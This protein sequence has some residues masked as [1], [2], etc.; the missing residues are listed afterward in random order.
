[1][2]KVLDSTVRSDR[3]GQVHVGWDLNATVT[4]NSGSTAS[5]EIGIGSSIAGLGP[6]GNFRQSNTSDSSGSQE[7]GDHPTARWDTYYT[8]QFRH[9]HIKHWLA[10]SY[11]APKVWYTDEVGKWVGGP[12]YGAHNALAA[13]DCS[14]VNAVVDYMAATGERTKTTGATYSQDFGVGGYGFDLRVKSEQRKANSI[15]WKA[16][17]RYN[18][19]DICGQTPGKAWSESG[20][21]AS[22]T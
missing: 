7:T 13:K 21:T 17:T 20:L 2:R 12:N 18:R 14:F 9:Y 3:V 11:C 1:M 8:A 15:S 16:G 4:F 5:M 6:R 10:P 19:Y 22:D